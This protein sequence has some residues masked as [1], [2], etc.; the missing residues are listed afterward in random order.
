MF[1]ADLHLHA[2]TLPMQRN[3]KREIL[4][5]LSLENKFASLIIQLTYQRFLHL[6]H[7]S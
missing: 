1:P 2:D 7:S 5:D 4:L 6:V 3:K